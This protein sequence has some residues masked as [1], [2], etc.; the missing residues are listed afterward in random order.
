MV[1]IRE[2][3]GTD[4]ALISHTI[5]ESW[6]GAYQPLLDEAW[7]QRLPDEYWLPTMRAWLDSGRMYG[8][9]AERDGRAAGCVIF[10]RGRDE[11]HADWGEIVSLYVTPD[12]MGRGIGSALLADALVSLQEDGFDRVYLWAI[13]GSRSTHGFYG[14]HGFRRTDDRVQYRIGGRDVCD[15]R[16]VREG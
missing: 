12:A 10:G 2:A 13:E 3:S 16:Y 15:V 8:R 5:A 14:R 1:N 11:D 9:I 7:L 6:R 4:A